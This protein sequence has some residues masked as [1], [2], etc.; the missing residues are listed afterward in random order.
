VRLALVSLVCVLLVLPVWA[1]LKGQQANIRLAR[2]SW[3]KTPPRL[4]RRQLVALVVWLGAL[5]VVFGIGYGVT[6]NPVESAG[7]AAVWA[8]VLA[9]VGPFVVFGIGK[10]IARR[11]VAGT[12]SRRGDSTP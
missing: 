2:E 12:E 4:R 3:G 1:L 7:A 11:R 8:T 6:R 10:R 5:V 9:V